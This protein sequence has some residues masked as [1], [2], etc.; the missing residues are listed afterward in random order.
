[1]RP[2]AA[3]KSRKRGGL[4]PAK[5]PFA[6]GGDGRARAR[7]A[8]STLPKSRARRKGSL[9]IVRVGQSC[10]LPVAAPRVPLASASSTCLRAEGLALI[11]RYYGLVDVED[12]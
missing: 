4:G 7:G 1:M 9:V 6:E 10:R 8:A 5:R 12:I 3:S 11:S 2:R